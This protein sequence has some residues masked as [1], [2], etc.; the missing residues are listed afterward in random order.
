MRTRDVYLSG[1]LVLALASARAGETPSSPD[2]DLARQLNNLGGFRFDRGEYGRAESLFTRAVALG[3]P[4]AVLNLAA[5][6]R[7]EARYSE[8]EAMYQRALALRE[9]EAPRSPN[10]IASALCGLA[11]LYRDTARF[12][13]AEKMARR[14]LDLRQQAAERDE[15]SI[16]W[17]LN[18]VGMLAQAQERTAEAASLFQQALDTAEKA[19]SPDAL[20]MAD[21]LIN[22]GNAERT[23]GDL[24]NAERH[25]D[26]AIR[27]LGDKGDR[28]RTAAALNGLALVE[29]ARGDFKQARLLETRALVS[30]EAAVGKE[31]PD[32]SAA[33]SSLA[34]VDQDL[35]DSHKARELYR[36]ALAIDQR[37]LGPNHPRV[38]ADLNNLGA[39]AAL[40]H[41]YASAE[42][43]FRQAL[44]LEEERKPGS[45]ESAF[46]MANL[47]A[48]Y[49]R[50]KR[51]SEAL[52]LYRRAAGILCAEDRQG[53]LRV[54]AIL[55]EYAELL[56]AA[57]SFAEAEDADT[58]AMH[59]R[60][61]YVL[62]NHNGDVGHS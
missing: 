57:G 37:V 49:V 45:V 42:S 11:L 9:S 46:R 60:V 18:L 27:E 8:A 7:A 2:A 36:E 55:H 30:L 21:I 58:R 50:E 43:Y 52:A 62:T 56:R 51:S 6:L 26:R 47:A 4:D 29:R 19:P 44:R 16:A 33:L 38:G 48:L 39:A 15:T 13:E 20:T 24:G 54:A 32:Y 35:H 10:R 40:Q 5:T 17:T 31:H 34:L 53:D 14:A 22:M 12:A 23:S 41:D 28:V 25:L 3:Q 61:K 1:F 59:I